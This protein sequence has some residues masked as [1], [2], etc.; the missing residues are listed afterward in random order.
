M[1]PRDL[2]SYILHNYLFVSEVSY[3]RETLKKLALHA[4]TMNIICL[5]HINLFVK[6]YHNTEKKTMKLFIIS[7]AYIIISKKSLRFYWVYLLVCFWSVW[8][9]VIEWMDN[10][11]LCAGKDTEE[12]IRGL[13]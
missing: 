7:K 13:F 12:S 9:N 4:F 11:E 1:F 10:S 5:T 6:W 8:V 3:F 2:F